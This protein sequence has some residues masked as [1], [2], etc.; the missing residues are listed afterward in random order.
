LITSFRLS[1]GSTDQSCC[2]RSIRA[3]PTARPTLHNRHSSIKPL[4]DTAPS[5][6]PLRRWT[7]ASASKSP[8]SK[9]VLIQPFLKSRVTFA[10]TPAKSPFKFFLSAR[11]SEQP[12][13]M[14]LKVEIPSGLKDQ[15]RDRGGV[16]TTTWTPTHCAPEVDPVRDRTKKLKTLKVR[17]NEDSFFNP[18][19]R[20]T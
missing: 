9:K 19:Q 14:S 18:R 1:G 5:I 2:R 17:T 6:Q 7:H 11:R 13:R 8:S 15:G 10:A 12:A 3:K 16:C 4:T 20:G